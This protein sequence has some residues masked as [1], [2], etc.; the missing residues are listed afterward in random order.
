LAEGDTI[1]CVGDST[2]LTVSGAVD[3]LWNTGDTSN[4]V[5]LK[6]AGTYSCVGLNKRGCEKINYF[7]IEIVPPPNVDFIVSKY[8]LSGRENE[9]TCSVSPQ[10]DVQYNWD[11]GDGL[12][13]TG[14]KPLHV[15]NISNGTLAYTIALTATDKYG[16]KNSSSEIIDVIPFIPNIF[17]PNGDGTNDVFMPEI[18]LQV[19]DRNGM[20]IF[21]G[22]EGWDGKFKGQLV[23]PDTYFYSIFYND[24]FG[25]EQNKKGYVTLV[26]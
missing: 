16:C 23:D 6:S 24:R 17:S 22:T 11:M 9:L 12:S 15:Y 7:N 19:F 25:E 8:T 10:P 3:Y 21:K 1:F 5:L 14:P 20:V 2:V 18:K 4:S 13:E 26:R